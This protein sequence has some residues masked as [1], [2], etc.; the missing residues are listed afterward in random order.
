[1]VKRLMPGLWCQRACCV[2]TSTHANWVALLG[3]NNHGSL[4]FLVYKLR[5]IRVIVNLQGYFTH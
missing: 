4:G 5:V 1:M 2:P 3:E